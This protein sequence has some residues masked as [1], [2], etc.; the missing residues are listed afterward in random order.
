MVIIDPLLRRK[1]AEEKAGGS[2]STAV[3]QG[4][5]QGNKQQSVSHATQTQAST[6]VH[7]LHPVIIRDVM[8]GMQAGSEGRTLKTQTS[9][10]PLIV[11]SR[12]VRSEHGGIV[13][14]PNHPITTLSNGARVLRAPVIKANHTQNK[15]SEGGSHEN[16]GTKTSKTSKSI[17]K[18]IRISFRVCNQ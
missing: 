10:H 2:K 15:A 17:S 4:D 6:H 13:V 8:R 9:N 16:T 11:N 3:K 5:K 12:I 14:G 7:T 18:S 1:E